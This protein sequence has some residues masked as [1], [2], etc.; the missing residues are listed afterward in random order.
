MELVRLNLIAVNAYTKG[1]VSPLVL[2]AGSTEAM[3]PLDRV[4]HRHRYLIG[5]TH[6]P[7]SLSVFLHSCRFRI[8]SFVSNCC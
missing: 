8:C 7:R 2:C 4:D 5:H 3:Q 6:T 1:F